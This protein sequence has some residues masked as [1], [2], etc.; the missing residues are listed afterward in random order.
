MPAHNP[1][2]RITFIKVPYNHYWDRNSVSCYRQ[3]GEQLVKAEVADAAVKAGYA[4]EAPR[5]A[6]SRRTS[7]KAR[8]DAGPDIRKDAG[9]G[10]TGVAADDSAGLRSGMAG[11][12]E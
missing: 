7:A 1:P 9:M 8:A 4:I 2:C 3:L 5:K 11:S 10:G 6:T 12:A